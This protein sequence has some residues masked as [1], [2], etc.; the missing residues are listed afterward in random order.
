MHKYHTDAGDTTLKQVYSNCSLVRLNQRKRFKL[1]PKLILL[2]IS[3][4]SL[5][6]SIRVY[7]NLHF[8]YSFGKL[9]LYL[10]LFC[11][12]VCYVLSLLSFSTT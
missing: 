2:V 3:A 6:C 10:P 9:G 5:L 1:V 12:F 7:I 11:V 4:R 8:Y